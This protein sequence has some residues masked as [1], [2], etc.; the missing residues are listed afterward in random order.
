MKCIF[1]YELSPMPGR[2]D[3][4]ISDGA[5]VLSAQAINDRIQVWVM[6]NS[7]ASPARYRFHKVFTGQEVPPNPG[8]FIGTVVMG[9]GS[10]V[11]HIFQTRLIQSAFECQNIDESEAEAKVLVGVPA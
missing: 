8:K 7:K 10:L 2:Q 1:K 5:E 6:V 11:V 3:V 9:N 4:W